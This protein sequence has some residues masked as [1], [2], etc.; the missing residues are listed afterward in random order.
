MLRD[1]NL[2]I[3]Y[4]SENDDILRDFFVPCFSACTSFDR[5]VDYFPLRNLVSLVDGFG[6]FAAGNV[7]MRLIVGHKFG[8]RD[9]NT[10]SKIFLGTYNRKGRDGPA[11][12]RIM[13]MVQQKRIR[14]RI[15]VPASDESSNVFNERLGIFSDNSGNMVAFSGALVYSPDREKEL[16]TVDVFTSWNDPERVARK[17]RNFQ[18]LWEDRAK[19]VRIHEFADANRHGMLKYSSEWAVHR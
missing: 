11:L 18:Y 1:L 9:I 13:G 19:F 16:E 2:K 15:A 6:D 10:L 8:I 5:C 3:E 7:R 17:R 14:I 12:D 4:N